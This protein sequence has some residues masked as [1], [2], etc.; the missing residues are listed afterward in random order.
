M[1]KL[2]ILISFNSYGEWTRLSSNVDGD[3]SAKEISEIL[4]RID[5][6]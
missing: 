3:T 5:M 4:K 6:A 1:K 2:T